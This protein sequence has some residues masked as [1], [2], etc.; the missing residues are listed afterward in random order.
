ML[1]KSRDTLRGKLMK[2]GSEVTQGHRNR[3]GSIRYLWLPSSYTIKGTRSDATPAKNLLYHQ[4]E[5]YLGCNQAGLS[6]ICWTG[7]STNES[8]YCRP[9]HA[10]T[11]EHQLF[12]AVWFY[13][14]NNY[15]RN[16]FASLWT[17]FRYRLYCTWLPVRK[18]NCLVCPDKLAKTVS[19]PRFFWVTLERAKRHVNNQA[20]HL[21]YP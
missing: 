16:R 2:S 5:Y 6:G 11:C 4:L 21:T 12:A 20:L 9:R 10:T 14:H 8:F 7:Y 19:N 13:G 3:H 17:A 18:A 15:W 1:I